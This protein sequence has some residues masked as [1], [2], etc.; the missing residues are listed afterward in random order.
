MIDKEVS[1]LRRRFRQDRNSIGKIHGC[2]VNQFG[3]I[4][5]TFEDSMGLLPVEE[6]EKYLELLKKG[7]SGTLG[8]TLTDIVFSTAQ[9]VDSPEHKLLMQLR[10][11]RLS[12]PQVL[13]RFYQ[14]VAGALRI[15]EKSYLILLAFDCYDVPFRSR[16]GLDQADSGD[17]Q[18][19]YVVCS[20]CPVK[21]TTP[22][23][24]YDSAEQAF[25]NRGADQVVAAPELGFLF[26]AFDD[27]A[28]NLYGALYYNRNKDTGYPEF[29]D[30]V[31]HTKP[32]MALG[33]QTDS[34]RQV[35]TESL[36]EECRPQ[37][38]QAVHTAL[39]EMTQLHKEARAEEPLRVSCQEVSRILEQA[40]VSEPRAASFRVNYETSFGTD[41]ELPPQ[42]L[43]N[44]SQ[45]E[46]KTPD[47]TVKVN[48]DRGDLVQ[49]REL[50]GTK[51]LLINID[52]GVELNGVNLRL[53]EPDDGRE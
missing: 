6:Q 11:T 34:F 47:V 41:S 43:L 25:H 15:P 36:E 51:F 35:L 53:D 19:S 39:R 33:A 48:P 46:Y 29:V 22:V 4:V 18:F 12:D 44:A 16:D 38:V 9:V 45:L 30:A 8:K 7:I 52:E 23:L 10:D 26:P 31:F 40:G 37:V 42:N 3:E 49:L 2:Y 13:D 27:R 5:T 1:E 14:T 28:A 32:P 24:R 20:I 17:T 50:G 21:E